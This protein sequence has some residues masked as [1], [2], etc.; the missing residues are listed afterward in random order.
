MTKYTV[1][2]DEKLYYLTKEIEADSKEKAIE[3]Y[4]TAWEKGDVA[5]NE[6]EI[7]EVRA[8]KID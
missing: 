8:E 7:V 4:M 3:K 5:V 1:S 6:N 2:I